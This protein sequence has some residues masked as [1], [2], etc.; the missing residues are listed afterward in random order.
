MARK[1]RPGSMGAAE[2]KYHRNFRIG[3]AIVAALV[4]SLFFV[5]KTDMHDAV[6]TASRF[7]NIAGFIITL[8]GF[9]VSGYCEELADKFNSE[10]KGIAAGGLALIGLGL[11]ISVGF[12]V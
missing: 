6:K 9:A 12:N 8:A 2:Q 1:F 4:L 11:L 3:V 7:C 10:G 5:F